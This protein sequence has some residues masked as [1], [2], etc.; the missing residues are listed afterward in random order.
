[1]NYILFFC[2]LIAHTSYSYYT[3]LSTAN[4]LYLPKINKSLLFL[5]GVG[6][7]GIIIIGYSLHVPYF[8]LFLPLYVAYLLELLFISKPSFR[9]AAFVTSSLLIN[10]VTI[11]LTASVLICYF[12]K[13]SLKQ[14][15]SNP[16]FFYQG[17]LFTNIL[18]LVPFI[19]F[20][21]FLPKAKLKQ[22]AYAR[23]Y[24]DIMTC[25]FT[26]LLFFVC[27]DISILLNRVMLL[28]LVLSTIATV[29][30][31]L[32]LCYC[33]FYFNTFLAILHPYKRKADRAKNV[34]SKVIEKTA[35]TEYKLYFDDLT[36]LYNRRFIFS[37]LDQICTE[38]KDSFGLVFL[39]LANLKQVNDTYGHNVGDE[40]IT[41][42]AHLL[43]KSIRDNDFAARIGGDEFLIILHDVT[44]QN[45]EMI[46][47]RIQSAIKNL[48]TKKPFTF[49]GNIG[50]KRFNMASSNQSRVEIINT[51]DELMNKDKAQFY[52]K[53]D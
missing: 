8:F 52:Q 17:F 4:T 47:H 19:I 31:I 22:V 38:S 24:A 49:H 34:H 29:I 44:D 6:N 2:S 21:K 53:R 48:N 11:N 16:T 46:I 40:Y 35:A 36:S 10:L 43:K 39:D 9:P 25:I 7:T 3:L 14:F 18:L 20:S 26:M 28:E 1:M 50:Y 33:I 13:I 5:F 42:M 45:L 15:Y 12:Q 23:I 41:D 27:F 51:V 30:F 32:V 37:K